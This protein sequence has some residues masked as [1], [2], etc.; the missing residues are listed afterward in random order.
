M[1][2]KLRLPECTGSVLVCYA[3]KVFV[4]AFCPASPSTFAET[5]INLI[6][7]TSVDMKPNNGIRLKELPL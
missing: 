3:W 6:T 4:S 1:Q 5:D 7:Q 2:R